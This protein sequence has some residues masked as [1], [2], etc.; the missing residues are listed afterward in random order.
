MGQL[1]VPE[2]VAA[3]ST[4]GGLGLLATS[5]STPDDVR[6]AIRATRHLT[7]APFGAN[8]LLH[9]PDADAIVEVLAGEQVPVVNLALGIDR[10]V[11]AALHDRGAMVVS[12]VTTVRHARAAQ[13]AGVDALIATGHEAAGHGGALTTLVLVASL[14][15]EI[16]L[17]VIAAGGITDGRGLAAALA[18]GAAGVSMGSR[19][20]MSVE[21]PLHPVVE[22]ALRTATGADTLVTDRI[23]G[24]P[25]RVLATPLA[26]TIGASREPF[27]PQHPLGRDTFASLRLGHLDRGVVAIGQGIGAITDRPT[28]AA[29]IERTVTEAAALLSRRANEIS[30]ISEPT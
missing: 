24:L 1:A 25:S 14:T 3:V 23:D 19:F 7:D 6:A 12:T 17:P 22:R 29:I 27:D 4:A 9:A 15:R 2:L 5:T 18:L 16:D 11:V 28:C 10:D 13:R 8:V 30:E 20:A 21:S 26:R